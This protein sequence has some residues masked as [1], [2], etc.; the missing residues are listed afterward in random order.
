MLIYVPICPRALILLVN[1][2]CCNVPW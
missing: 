1:F 2:A